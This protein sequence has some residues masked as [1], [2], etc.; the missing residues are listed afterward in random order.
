MR[1]LRQSRL[2]LREYANELAERALKCGDVFD[3]NELMRIFV[4]GL[5]ENTRRSVQHYWSIYRPIHMHALVAY[6]VSI[7]TTR[8]S[9]TCELDT[10]EQK[11][12]GSAS[13]A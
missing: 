3:D 5:H 12:N 1:Y 13:L 9:H 4:E 2:G 6:A 8:I 10:R 7:D 11:N